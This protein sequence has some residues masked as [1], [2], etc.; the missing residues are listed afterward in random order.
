[1]A[2]KFGSLDTASP[3]NRLCR[4]FFTSFGTKS[5]VYPDH[6][7]NKDMRIL[8]FTGKGGV[9]KT[10]LAAARKGVPKSNERAAYWFRRAAN[11][12]SDIS[13]VF[14]AIG[15]LAYMYRD[16]R[17]NGNNIDAYMWLAV[18]DASVDPPIDQATDDDLE[19]VAK[20]MTKL[21]IVEAQRKTRDWANHHLRLH[22]LPGLLNP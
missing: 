7:N 19:R 21:E 9:G 5:L 17:L 20:R 4:Y 2:G 3:G 12:F 10:S 16:E 13:G 22:K 11:H 1:M 15:E 8:M 18:V 6:Y 14:S